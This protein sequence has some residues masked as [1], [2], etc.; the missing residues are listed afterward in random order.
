[1]T[2]MTRTANRYKIIIISISVGKRFVVKKTTV[3]SKLTLSRRS[4]RGLW[5]D[6]MCDRVV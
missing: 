3:P 1:M 5:S 6:I 4:M 2:G